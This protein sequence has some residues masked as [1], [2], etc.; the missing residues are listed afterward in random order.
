MESKPLR[1]WTYLLSNVCCKRH[2]FRVQC[3]PQI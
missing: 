3:S 1:Q 2:L